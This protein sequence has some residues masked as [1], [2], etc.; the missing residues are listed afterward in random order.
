MAGKKFNLIDNNTG[1]DEFINKII[2]KTRVNVARNIAGRKFTS[3]SSSRD[4]NVLLEAVKKEVSSMKKFEDFRFYRIKDLE[5]SQRDLLFRDYMID[6]EF[7]GNMQGRGLFAGNRTHGEGASAVIINSEDHINI[8]SVYPGLNIY[9]AYNEVIK[10]EKIFEKKFDF[11]FD[12]DLG[13]LT[14][15]PFNLG[16]ALRIHIIAHL[17]VVVLSSEI[18]DLLKRMSRVGCQ[19][20]GYFIEQ[21]EAA[22]NL[23]EIFNESTLGRSEDDILE[24][25]EAICLNVAEEEENARERLKKKDLPGIKDNVYRSFGLLKYA[26]I[27]SYEESLE[28]LSV[29]KLGVDL[30][31]IDNV[32]DFDFF[33]LVDKISNSRIIIDMELGGKINSDYIDSIRADMIRKKITKEAD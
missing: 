7:T 2:L 21:S 26:K 6:T 27:L 33:E 5:N 16:T 11:A 15:S 4:K 31:I 8:Q 17:P 1:R 3:T 32:S 30:D 19:V 18:S 29:I 10:I 23:F 24:E 20:K 13:Y 12:K 14:A 9:E 25:V 22:G 28:L